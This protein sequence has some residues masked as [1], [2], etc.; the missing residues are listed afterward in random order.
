[1]LLSTHISLAP[2][3]AIPRSDRVPELPRSFKRNRSRAAFTESVKEAR[4]GQRTAHPD[5]EPHLAC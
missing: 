5:R 4:E 2:S 1:M 3:A